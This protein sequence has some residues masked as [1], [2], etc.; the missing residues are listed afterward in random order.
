MTAADPRPGAAQPLPESGAPSGAHSGA[1]SGAPVPIHP[2]PPELRLSAAARLMS[3]Q[4]AGDPLVAGQRFL[5]AAPA[6][7]IDLSLMFCTLDPASRT[8]RQ[9]VLAVIGTGRT[10]MLFV[11]GPDRKARA[12]SSTLRMAWTPLTAEPAHHERVALVRHVTAVLSTP[13]PQA[14]RGVRLVQS[15]V[16]TKERE[17]MLACRDAGFI[18]LGELAYMRRALPKSGLDASF[19]PQRADPWPAGV[20]VL[21]VEDL[22][23]SSG[24]GASTDVLLEALEATYVNTLDCPELCG[25]R[26]AADVLESHRSVGVYDPALWWLVMHEGK[27]RGCMLLTVCPE[28]DSVELVYLGLAPELRGKG[29]GKRLLRMGMAALYRT[30]VGPT[31]RAGHP[32]VVGGGGLTCAVDT[33]NPPAVE[34]YR[35]LGFQRFGV[36]VPMVLGLPSRDGASA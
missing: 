11:S 27:P 13:I 26:T 28:L 22:E 32:H 21:T 35:G 4:A 20:S 19:D 33:R 25:L 7:G 18:Q 5:D 16:E 9:A 8:V 10:A 30:A 29:L 17:A 2:V 3:E 24:P 34:L 31:A 23:K 14:P 1:H 12:W 36:R 15:L 6:L